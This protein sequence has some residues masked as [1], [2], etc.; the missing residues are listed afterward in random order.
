MATQSFESPTPFNRPGVCR[1]VVL[2][3]LTGNFGYTAREFLSFVVGYRMLG[4]SRVFGDYFIALSRRQFSGVLLGYWQ[5]TLY[6][7]GFPEQTS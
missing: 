6:L 4:C 5:P 3:S 1:R 7:E 2:V